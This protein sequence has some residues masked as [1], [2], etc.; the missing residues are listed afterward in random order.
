[1]KN[2]HITCTD[3]EDDVCACCGKEGKGLNVCNKCKG[4]KYCNLAC[5]KKHRKRHKKHCESRVA[6]LHDI[7]LFKQPPPRED[8]PICMLPPPP[9]ESGSRYKSCCGKAICSGCIHAVEIRDKGVGLC[10]FCRT[11]APYSDEENVRRLKKRVEVGDAQALSGL[12]CF[13]DL[14]RYGLP[15]DTTKARELY[16]RA[17]ELGLAKAYFNIGN[18][19]HHG[20]GVERDE[21][22]TNHY[23]E[24]AAMGGMS[25]Q[26]IILDV[27][28]KA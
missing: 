8:C 15:R 13:Y 9:L 16:H 3:E 1:M 27:W 28:S 23:Y 18:T 7:E 10:P 26:G 12:G 6:E 20:R 22:K 5:K 21:K 25:M 2:L 11:P 14:G 24:L 17:G 19:Y 4:A